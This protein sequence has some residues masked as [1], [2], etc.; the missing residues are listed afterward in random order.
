VLFF[1]DA[2]ANV[3]AVDPDTGKELWTVKVDEHPNARITGPVAV[4]KVR[5]Y[6]AVS[7]LE[8]PLSHDPVY[9]CCTFRGS[10]VALD[11]VTGKILWKSYSISTPPALLHERTSAGA[12][13]Y[14]PAGGAIYAPITIDAKRNLLYAATAESYHHDQTAGSNAI[15]AFDWDSGAHRWTRQPQPRDNGTA[16]KHQDDAP[17]ACDNPASALFEFAA[18]AVLATLPNGKQ[19]LL[20]G[21]KSGVVYALDPNHHGKLLWERRVAQ[22]GTAGGILWLRGDRAD[23]LCAHQ[24]PGSETTL[25]SGRPRRLGLGIWKAALADPG[26]PRDLQ[27]G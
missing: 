17:D 15:I 4:H 9:P 18:P 6:A 14:G 5:V 12:E 8:D 2:R 1:G 20:A 22:G 10:V 7:S 19:V 11:A 25:H 13:L 16:C 21:Q 27:L 3:A 23:G 26:A 24:R